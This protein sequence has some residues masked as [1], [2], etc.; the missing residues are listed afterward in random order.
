MMLWVASP[1]H[2]I[3]GNCHL[4]ICSHKYNS[5]TASTHITDLYDILVHHKQ[6]KSVHMFLADGDPDFNPSHIAND[7]FYC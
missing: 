5:A 4:R 6:T 1:L 2:S 7:F 3:F